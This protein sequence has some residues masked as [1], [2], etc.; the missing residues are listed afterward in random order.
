MRRFC[1]SG[2]DRSGFFCSF[3]F[4]FLYFITHLQLQYTSGF[5]IFFLFVCFLSVQLQQA[6]GC[7]SFTSAKLPSDRQKNRQH[8]PI[9]LSHSA[10]F[11][12]VPV[13]CVQ[14]SPQAHVWRDGPG[15]D[16]KKAGNT[17][18]SS[19]ASHYGTVLYLHAR[20]WQI[21]GSDQHF[22]R[23]ARVLPSEPQRGLSH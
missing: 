8:F 3:S 13:C 12:C 18:S 6:L 2:P 9:I 16:R 17:V 1:R 15:P 7:C 5:L 4:L 20:G 14:S 10:L 19:R 21:A 11:F 23:L 22:R